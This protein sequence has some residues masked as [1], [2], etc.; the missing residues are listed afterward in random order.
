MRIDDQV[1]PLVRKVLD[2]VVKHE[3]DR[4][5]AA[6]QAV[7][8]AGLGPN[9]LELTA[10]ICGFVVFDANEGRPSPMDIRATSEAVAE[11]ESWAELTADEISAFLT[12]V[13]N[14]ARL[15]DAVGAQKGVMLTFV[16]TGSLLAA[17]PKIK[18]GEWWFNYLDR[19]EAALETSQSR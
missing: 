1:E 5:D 17:S 14:G 3:E 7:L 18:D 13:V 11:M 9:A 12:A 8:D 19:V 15:E 4:F 10:A 16:V 6:V 2:A